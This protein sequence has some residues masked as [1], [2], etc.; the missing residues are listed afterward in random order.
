MSIDCKMD[1]INKIFSKQ[2]DESV[3]EQFVRFGKG[4]YDGRAVIRLQ[5]GK[6]VKV[7]SGFEYAKDFAEAVVEMTHKLKMNGIIMTKDKI[8][9]LLR[10]NNIQAI[11]EEKKGGLFYLNKIEEQEIEA[12]KLKEILDKA[13]Y[14]LLNIS[15]PGILLKCKQKLPKPGKS[16]EKIDDKFCQITIDSK[17][18]PEIRKMF[19][20]DLPEDAKKVFV[21]H[22]IEVKN[23]RVPEGEKDFEKM[24]LVAKR[25][26]RIV[27]FLE[28]DKKETK[29]ECEFSV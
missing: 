15:A 1:F 21:K 4:T 5:R 17:Y 2:I 29:R 28:I 16:E 8:S 13:K 25:E 14:A 7:S 26:G 3:H 24:R 10:K 11:S 19:F 9:D 18:W 6:D 12:T 20:P 27:R 22:T 23:I